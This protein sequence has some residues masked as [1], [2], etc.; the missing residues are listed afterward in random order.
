MDAQVPSVVGPENLLRHMKNNHKWQ[1]IRKS[2]TRD[3][4]VQFFRGSLRP[5]SRHRAAVLVFRMIICDLRPFS[6]VSGSGFEEMMEG[7][8]LPC[9][10]RYTI[11]TMLNDIFAA[12][13]QKLK[14]FLSNEATMLMY[15]IAVDGWTC[16]SQGK[17]MYDLTIHFLTDKF[18]LYSLP[19]EVSA[20]EDKTAEGIAAWIQQALGHFGFSTK[21]K[22][23]CMTSDEASTEEK[24]NRLLKVCIV[25]FLFQ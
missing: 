24:T 22:L 2:A 7:F 11:A 5:I 4:K 12:K 13:Y 18:V 6:M 3:D 20:I 9:P 25:L 21:Q 1:P 14:K 15:S 17:S 8:N 10:S 23:F 19:L 16:S